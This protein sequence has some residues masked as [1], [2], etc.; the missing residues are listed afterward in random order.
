MNFSLDFNIKRN[1]ERLLLLVILVIIISIYIYIYIY[2][3][4]CFCFLKIEVGRGAIIF[5]FALDVRQLREIDRTS[6]N[7]VE[8]ETRQKRK[9][10]ENECIIGEF[11]ENRL[12]LSL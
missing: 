5:D 9:D 10:W 7:D 1:L 11:F 3:Y 8:S 12:D 4:I 2:I 6:L